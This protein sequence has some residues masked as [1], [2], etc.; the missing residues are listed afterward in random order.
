MSL[1]C[2]GRAMPT[3]RKIETVP[4]ARGSALGA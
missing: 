4:Q 1:W 3:L 2:G